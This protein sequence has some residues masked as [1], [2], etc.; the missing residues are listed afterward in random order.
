MSK[1][2]NPVE[3]LGRG[4]YEPVFFTEGKDMLMVGKGARDW[5]FRSLVLHPS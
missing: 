3:G 4:T 1:G 5:V 2:D